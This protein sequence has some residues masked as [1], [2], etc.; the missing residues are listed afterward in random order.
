[1][2][3][4]LFDSKTQSLR[5]FSPI[6]P[7]KVGLYV[8]G[9]TVQSAPHV[10]HLRSAVAFDVL[11][12]WM[13][14]GHGFEVTLVRNVTDVDD[15]ILANAA[16]AGVDWLELAAS[17][18]QGFNKVYESLNAVADKTPHATDHIVDMI[19][20]IEWLMSRGHAYQADDGSANVFFDSASWPEYGELTNQRLDNMEGEDVASHGRRRPTD[21]ALWKASK[22]D[23]PESASW[24]S[25]WGDGRPGWHI[26]CSAMTR[27]ALG[28]HFDIHGGG[29]DLRFP[30]HEN[31]LAQSRAA[32]FEF[33]NYWMH[34]GLVT[35]GGQKMSKSLGNGVSIGELF[36]QGSAL[37]VRYWLLSA[38]YR[39]SLDYSA[40]AISDAAAALA[41]IHNFV[42]R[43][44]TDAQVSAGHLPAEFISAMDAD[45]NV[46]SALGVIHEH[47]RAGNT[48]LDSG[49]DATQDASWVLAMLTALNLMPEKSTEVDEQLAV[50]VEA[51]I[52]ARA[53]A[54]AAKDFAL[55]DQIRQE[56]SA[57]G[58]TIEDTATKTTWSLN[59]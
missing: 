16:E 11:A 51:L 9:P 27:S 10:G 53:D 19:A 43:A 22:E 29:L 38:H 32:G 21:F 3:L 17:V 41:R 52:Q 8:C 14:F 1:M 20:L 13:R 47:V 4:N 23:E 33:A 6:T 44:S 48:K 2:S 7:G 24:A 54:R 56:I 31:E 42:K 39:T 25:P 55:A 30:H 15:K 46:P 18:E 5:E 28:E 12:G 45:L 49:Q 59:G 26:E 34:N 37:A 35:V 50:R 57:L 58:V 40:S 36:A